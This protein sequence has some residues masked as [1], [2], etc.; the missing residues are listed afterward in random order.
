[1]RSFFILVLLFLPIAANAGVASTSYVD[2][3]VA[4]QVRTTG[5]QEIDGVKTYNDSP[6]IPTPDLPESEDQASAENETVS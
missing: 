4:T 5:D 2:G 3:S 6:V 1:M